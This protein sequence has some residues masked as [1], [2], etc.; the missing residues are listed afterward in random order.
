MGRFLTTRRSQWAPGVAVLGAAIGIAAAIGLSL[1][2]RSWASSVG[3]LLTIGL[4]AGWAGKRIG[5]RE[6]EEEPPRLESPLRLNFMRDRKPPLDLESD[7]STNDQKYL[8]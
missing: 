2:I 8:M 5:D 7:A 1:G 4:L 6:R 3:L